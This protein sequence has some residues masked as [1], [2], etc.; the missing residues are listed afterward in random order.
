MELMALGFIGAVADGFC[1]CM[2]LIFIAKML[3][4]IGSSASTNNF[5]DNADNLWHSLNMVTAS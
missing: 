1:A 2:A 3:N 5:F 4:N